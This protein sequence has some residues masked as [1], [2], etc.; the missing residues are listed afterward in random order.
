ML[1]AALQA[2]SLK[3]WGAPLCQTRACRSCIGDGIINQCDH[4]SH[5]QHLSPPWWMEACCAGEDSLGAPH[6]DPRLS[7]C[8]CW[9]AASASSH[10]WM[11]CC[12]WG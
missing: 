6:P 7:L 11:D 9:S 3:A 2:V 10:F 1:A 12:L 5:L 4:T 8:E